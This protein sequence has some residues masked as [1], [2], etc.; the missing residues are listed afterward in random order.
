MLGFLTRRTGSCELAANLAGETFAGALS[1]CRRYR[2][3]EAPAVS[4]LLGIANN[5]LRESARRGRVDR[6]ARQRLGIP[7]LSLA[8]QDLA[9]VEELASVGQRALVLLE[10]LP[11]AQRDAVRWRVIEERGYSELA[12]TLTCSE[13]VVRQ[14]V[15]RGLKRLRTMIEEQP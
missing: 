4:W 7:P 6:R 11:P 5:K 15:S 9:R 13:Q 1:A 8:D 12:A 14:Q 10:R 3:D 2:P